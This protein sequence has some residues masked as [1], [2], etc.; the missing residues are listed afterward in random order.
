MINTIFSKYLALPVATIPLN[1]KPI[2]SIIYNNKLFNEF[3]YLNHIKRTKPVSNQHLLPW[4]GSSL[5]IKL[6]IL[7]FFFT[8]SETRTHTY[9]LEVGNSTIKLQALIK[10]TEYLG[11]VGFEPRSTR[12]KASC[13]NHYTKIPII[14]ST[15]IPI[16]PFN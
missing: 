7:I 15:K 16:I 9:R 4:Q 2:S 10:L 1:F 5:P 14:Y 3:K 12:L 13:I 6:L 11:L 8:P